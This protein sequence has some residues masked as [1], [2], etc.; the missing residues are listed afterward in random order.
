MGDVA[1]NKPREQPRQNPGGNK[2]DS[3]IMSPIVEKSK[4]KM[5]DEEEFLDIDAIGDDLGRIL[6]SSKNQQ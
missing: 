2:W 4:H 5:D 6:A 3:M 1:A